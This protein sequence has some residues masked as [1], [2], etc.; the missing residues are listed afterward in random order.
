[1]GSHILRVAS[2]DPDTIQLPAGST[3]HARTQSVWPRKVP[4]LCSDRTLHNPTDL[5]LEAETT[6]SSASMIALHF[7][8]PPVWRNS[9]AC[10]AASRRLLWSVIARWTLVGH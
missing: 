8:T 7:S 6:N 5:S 2:S 10:P 9:L 3:A 1:M 4:N